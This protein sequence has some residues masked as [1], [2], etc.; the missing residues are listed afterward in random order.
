MAAMAMIS[1]E[2]TWVLTCREPILNKLYQWFGLPLRH[3][4]TLVLGQTFGTGETHFLYNN[5][6]VCIR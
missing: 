1:F 5:V 4:S 3:K 6:A 2:K